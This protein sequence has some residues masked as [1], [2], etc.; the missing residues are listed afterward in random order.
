MA[1]AN[2]KVTSK[3]KTEQMNGQFDEIISVFTSIKEEAEDVLPL[4]AQSLEL[5]IEITKT[6]KKAF[7]AGKKYIK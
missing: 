6:Y 3:E 5:T 2:K 7:N 4:L 1:K